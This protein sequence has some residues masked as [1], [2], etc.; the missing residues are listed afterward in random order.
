MAMLLRDYVSKEGSRA[1]GYMK[2]MAHSIIAKSKRAKSIV[3][4]RI[5]E[6]D[7]QI[8]RILERRL[9]LL[10]HFPKAAN[11]FKKHIIHSGS[12]LVL[13]SDAAKPDIEGMAIN[14]V[15]PRTF[16]S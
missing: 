8:L 13:L 4:A 12:S 10:Q 9:I 7:E 14:E 16:I 11:E 3:V 5:Q 1:G 15:N 6:E 2:L